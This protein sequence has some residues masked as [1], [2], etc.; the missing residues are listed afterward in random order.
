[1]LAITGL[2][3]HDLLDTFTQQDV[4][5]DKLFMDVAKYNARVMGPTH[6]ENVAHLAC[7]TALTYRG[8][9]HIAF[10]VDLQEQAVDGTRSPRNVQ[11]HMSELL[12]VSARLPSDADLAQAADILSRGRKVVILAGTRRVGGRC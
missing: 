1:V 9:A 4:A 11:A 12:A 8:V 10:P 7:R 2:P 5:L 3:H 6:V